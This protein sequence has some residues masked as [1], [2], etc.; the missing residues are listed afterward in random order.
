MKLCVLVLSYN[1]FQEGKCVRGNLWCSWI[2]IV[3]IFGH[4]DCSVAKRTLRILDD[5]G[6]M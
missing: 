3:P 5:Y 2:D 6:N 4:C 1:N